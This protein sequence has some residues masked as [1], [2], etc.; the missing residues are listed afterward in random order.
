MVICPHSTSLLKERKCLSTGSVAAILESA[1]PRK[2]ELGF[3]H[4]PSNY[5]NPL[6]Q[7]LYN[8]SKGYPSPF[9]FPKLKSF[10]TV[11][12]TC[13][14]I[15]FQ[16]GKLFKRGF[17]VHWRPDLRFTLWLINCGFPSKNWINAMKSL[18][19]FLF[20]LTFWFTHQQNLIWEKHGHLQKPESNQTS[21]NNISLA[22][23]WLKNPNWVKLG[24]LK[25]QR[26][27]L[28][29]QEREKPRPWLCDSFSWMEARREV[30]ATIINSII[31]IIVFIIIILNIF[32]NNNNNI[33]QSGWN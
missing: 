6:L 8:Q 15:L 10:S 1:R 29:S 17:R 9:S 7:E 11:L 20:T 14:N 4:F 32:N 23:G 31:T 5:Q 19:S 3:F 13:A 30:I 26:L 12:E 21:L 16:R 18:G 2:G 25:N 28:H 33:P 24:S 27:I 22:S